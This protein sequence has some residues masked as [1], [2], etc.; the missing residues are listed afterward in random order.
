MMLYVTLWQ[1][2]YIHVQYTRTKKGVKFCNVCTTSISSARASKHACCLCK[3]V[4]DLILL[5]T[6]KSPCMRL[7]TIA[8][9]IDVY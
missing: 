2:V 6:S 4:Y 8:V 7:L 9:G 3:A 5:L 1:R